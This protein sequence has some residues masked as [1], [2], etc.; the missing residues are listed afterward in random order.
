MK[1]RSIH[2]SNNTARYRT[3]MGYIEG[4][5]SIILNI[6]LFGFKYWI[7]LKTFSVAIIADAWHTLSDSLTSVIVIIGF[8][9]TSQPADEKH[10][11]GHGRIELVSSVVIGTLLA[12]VGF[13][14]LMESVERFINQQSANY[15][16][17]AA[18]LFIGSTIVKEGL[19][20]FS[21]R[22]GKKINSYAL[23]ADGWHHRSDAIVSFIIL[24][25]IFAGTY[26]WWVD[27][28]L[29]IIVSLLIFYTTYQI[30]K[31]AISELIGEEADNELKSRIRKL[32]KSNISRDLRV[33]HLHLHKYG[34]TKELT[35]HIC[36]P[37]DMDLD[38]A[39]QVASV[40]EEKIKEEM[41]INATIHVEPL[42]KK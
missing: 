29:G 41:D 15:Q 17:F 7:G 3:S 37:G 32:A 2:N 8:W 35:F 34:N 11:F 19:A 42:M 10:P 18:V 33:H 13:N 30:L 16:Y 27:S 20:Q 25:G 5:V 14:F 21:I 9:V 1:E 40:L 23:L 28:L 31:K 6:L 26:Y 4:F 36:L 12:I 24:I 22:I 38:D 39:H